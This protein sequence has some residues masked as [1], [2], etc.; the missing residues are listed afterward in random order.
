M[1]TT[2]FEFKC[3]I[4]G[5]SE[6]LHIVYES[7]LV[8]NFF[9]KKLGAVTVFPTRGVY[10]GGEEKSMVI[11]YL[12][13]KTLQERV[14]LRGFLPDKKFLDSKWLAEY[15]GDV[16]EEALHWFGQE[17]ALV[18]FSFSDSN[19]V[20]TVW[21]KEILAIRNLIPKRKVAAARKYWETWGIYKY[22]KK[23]SD[24]WGVNI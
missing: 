15:L 3:M 11:Y 23:F 14:F 9:I 20:S 21:N 2:N 13:E 19:S 6:V 10:S 4:S 12:Y 22:D 7:K 5:E 8:E 18:T 17:S 1:K 16:V 24:S